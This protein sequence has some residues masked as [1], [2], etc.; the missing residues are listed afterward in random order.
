RALRVGDGVRGRGLEHLPLGVEEEHVE[1]RG[2]L[3]QRLARRLQRDGGGDAL[4]VV[5]GEEGHVAL[6]LRQRV[7]RV[8]VGRPHHGGVHHGVV[9]GVGVALGRDV[10]RDEG[11]GDR[12]RGRGAAGI[13]K[14]GERGRVQAGLRQR[15]RERDLARRGIQGLRGVD[16]VA[17]LVV[18]RGDDLA[19]GGR[20]DPGGELLRL[21]ERA[22]GRGRQRDALAG[23]LRRR[24]LEGERGEGHGGVAVLR[25]VRLVDGARGDRA[26]LLDAVARLVE[27]VLAALGEEEELRVVE[28]VAQHRLPHQRDVHLDGHL[29]VVGDLR[30][31]GIR[32]VGL[33]VRGVVDVHG[34]AV[35]LHAHV[36]PRGLARE[37]ERDGDGVRGRDRRVPLAEHL[38][39][40]V[41][42]GVEGDGEVGREVRVAGGGAVDGDDGVDAPARDARLEA[43]GGARVRGR[44]QREGGRDQEKGQSKEH[45]TAHERSRPS[46]AGAPLKG[47]PA[48]LLPEG[49]KKRHIGRPGVRRSMRALALLAVLA[50]L[51]GCVATD[52]STPA[53]TGPSVGQDVEVGQ[54]RVH[55]EAHA[56]GLSRLQLAQGGE[57]TVT[58]PPGFLVQDDKGELRPAKD[59]VKLTPGRTLTFLPPWNA[60]G[61][62]PL[63]VEADGQKADLNLTYDEGR[64]LVSGDLAVDLLKVQRERFPHRTPGMPNYAKAEAYFA[65]FFKSLNYTVEI[66][67]YPADD[68][69][70]PAGDQ[71]GPGSAESVLGYKKGTTQADRYLVFGGHFDVVE[72]TTEGAFDNTAGAVATLAMA[73]AFANLTTEH[74][75]VFAEWGGEED[76][77]VGSSA[78]LA[79]HPQ[80]VPYIDGYVNFD[81]VALAWPAPKI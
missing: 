7:A 42:G 14:D 16:E 26:E 63:S 54:A 37:L 48:N 3:V 53:G 33:H 50:L 65:D 77:I 43:H 6:H 21:P 74:T 75:L 2:A 23:R 35:G 40:E 22:G 36:D 62:P 72:G 56:A 8:A 27:A 20:V 32:G 31:R 39:A 24:G 73:R 13:G 70:V 19:R 30:A 71:P 80:L 34:D 18:E 28:P 59:A 69:K 67:A 25:D 5:E 4:R 55:A 15:R 1:A 58:F 38:E 11:D 29:V 76:G 61:L 78:W 49:C 66:N 68:Q 46:R 45:P 60:T 81:V 51:A 41:Q 12:D 44:G 57:A 17:P 9:L 47:F 10:A 64:R 79:A 52:P